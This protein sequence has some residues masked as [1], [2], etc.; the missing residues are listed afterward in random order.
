[1]IRINDYSI[2]DVRIDGLLSPQN[3]G[4]GFIQRGLNETDLYKPRHLAKK[5]N[6]I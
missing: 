5:K 3:R 2:S 1:V 4:I 6:D